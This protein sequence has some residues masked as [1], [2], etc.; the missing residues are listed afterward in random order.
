MRSAKRLSV[1]AGNC[2]WVRT[3]SRKVRRLLKKTGLTDAWKLSEADLQAKWYLEHHDYKEAKRKRAHQWRLEYLET[4]LAAVQSAKKGNIKACTR[5]AQ[6]QRMAQKEETQR[7]R[8]A[9]GKGFSG[10]LQ[11]IKVAQAAQDGTPHWVTCQSKR[12]VE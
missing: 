6:V 10:G 8:K 12:L 1:T 11:Q 5:R 2:R 4:R 9:Q 7:R 3:S